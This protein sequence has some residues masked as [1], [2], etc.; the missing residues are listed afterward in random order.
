MKKLLV[1]FAITAFAVTAFTQDKPAEAPAPKGCKEC[2]KVEKGTCKGDKK[3][4]KKDGCKKADC[5]KA[6]KA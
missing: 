3:C 5:P 2:C 6:K 1:S 4:E